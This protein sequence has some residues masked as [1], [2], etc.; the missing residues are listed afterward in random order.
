MLQDFVQRITGKNSAPCN[1]AFGE[2]QS[3]FISG[4]GG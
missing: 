4:N 1:G 3:S 2:W